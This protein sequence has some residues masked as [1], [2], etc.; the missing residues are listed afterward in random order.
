MPHGTE[1]GHFA[2]ALA[3]GLTITQALALFAG[4]RSSSAGNDPARLAGRGHGLYPCGDQL[5]H[6]D[7]G[8]FA[9]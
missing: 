1:I 4:A 7:T 9:I 3:F 5:C 8:L 2:L 6:A